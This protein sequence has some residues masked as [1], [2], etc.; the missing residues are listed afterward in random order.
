MRARFARRPTRRRLA[1]DHLATVCLVL[2]ACGGGWVLLVQILRA[3][4]PSY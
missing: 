2:A 4:T 3:L 1:W